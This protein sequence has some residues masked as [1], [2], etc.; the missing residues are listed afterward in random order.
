MSA[1]Q[2][3]ELGEVEEVA[4]LLETDDYTIHCDG[5]DF[6]ALFK[7]KGPG[8]QSF[9]ARVNRGDFLV[10]AGWGLDVEVVGCR[11]FREAWEDDA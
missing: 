6:H 1:L 7:K 4:Q 10:R 9:E 5:R 3:L 2:L 11:E 8:G